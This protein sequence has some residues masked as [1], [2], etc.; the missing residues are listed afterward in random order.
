M[1]ADTGAACKK[2]RISKQS[3][4]KVCRVAAALPEKAVF[5][6]ADAEKKQENMLWQK[7][8]SNIVRK[9]KMISSFQVLFPFKHK[10]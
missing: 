8:I 10:E 3:R 5:S 6:G 4:V 9:K 7:N 1:A 2:G